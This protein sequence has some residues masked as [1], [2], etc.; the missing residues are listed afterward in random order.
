MLFFCFLRY[1][2]FF[3]SLFDLSVSPLVCVHNTWIIFMISS[4]EIDGLDEKKEVLRG[5]VVD[6]GLW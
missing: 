4:Y 5:L 2:F 1:N 3:L 6:W